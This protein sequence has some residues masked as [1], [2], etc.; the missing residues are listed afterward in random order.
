MGMKIF[1]LVNLNLVF[2]LPIENFNVDYIFWIVCKRALIFHMSI[3]SDKAFPWVPTFVTLTYLL[4][5]LTLALY[6]E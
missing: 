2:D 6:F 3:P 5:T 1:D 4:K